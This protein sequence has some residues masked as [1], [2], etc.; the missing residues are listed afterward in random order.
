MWKGSD[1]LLAFVYCSWGLICNVTTYVEYYGSLWYMYWYFF[2]EERF[3]AIE[4][5]NSLGSLS[6]FFLLC[7]ITEE[8]FYLNFL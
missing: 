4:I 1:I 5:K 6:V 7:K 8:K 3:E 2:N